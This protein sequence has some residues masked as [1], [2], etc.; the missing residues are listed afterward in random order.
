MSAGVENKDFGI[1]PMDTSDSPWYWFYQ[2]E[3]G[4]WHRVEDDPMSS[5]NSSDLENYYFKN[6]Q[7]VL[8]IATAGSRFRIN[9]PE[10]LKINLNTGQ[11]RRIKRSFATEHTLRC[12][13]AEQVSSIPLHWDKMDHRKPYEV[14]CLKWH[15][16]EYKE[17]EKYVR[18]IGLLNKTIKNIYRIQ[19]IDLWE[20]YCRKRTQLM[21]IKGQSQI[22]EQM[23]FHGTSQYNVQSICKYNFDCNLSDQRRSAHIFGKGTYFAKHATLADT[24]SVCASPGVNKLYTMFLARVTVGKYTMGQEDLC[25]PDGNQ[26][27]NTHD[28]CV[29]NVMYPRTFVIFNSN[30]IYPEYVLEY[31][32]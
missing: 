20:L 25:K 29:D 21:R 3:C 11:T 5:L 6:P 8:D 30:Q 1:E 9:F 31:C 2:A 10:C 32:G 22:E 27:E 19:N 7:G 23:L 15:T 14:F 24:Y 4:I 16:N 26:I 12:K 17:V 13:C 18:E 28:S